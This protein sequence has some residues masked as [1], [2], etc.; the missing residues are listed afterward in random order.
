LGAAFGLPS[1]FEGT[2]S[3]FFDYNPDTGLTEWFDYDEMT[4]EA[5]ISYEQDVSS[6][7]KWA[8][9]NRDDPDVW[10]KG[11]KESWALYAKI[12]AIVQIQ[13]RKKGIDINNPE[14]ADRVFR[15]I[16]Q[17]YPLLKTTTKTVK[18]HN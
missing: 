13:M 5:T 2:M 8:Q 16:N 7:L 1:L 10:K 11:V 17:N 14:H 3:Q 12:P 18:S 9:E 15:E 4:G 6:L